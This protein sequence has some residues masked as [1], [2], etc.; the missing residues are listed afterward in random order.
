M[1]SLTAIIPRVLILQICK[2]EHFTDY[3]ADK[4]TPREYRHSLYRGKSPS[5]SG[6]CRPIKL[7]R[8]AQRVR[9]CRHERGDYDAPAAKNRTV[10][11]V[12]A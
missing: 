2:R 4:S 8:L 10:M 1:G 12:I 3:N 6:N 11:S 9:D 7:I 5:S